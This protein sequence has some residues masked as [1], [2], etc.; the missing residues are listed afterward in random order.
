IPTKGAQ[1]FSKEAL[2]QSK[3][4]VAAQ[5]YKARTLFDPYTTKEAA[6]EFF[7][8]APKKYQKMIG[9]STFGVDL[10]RPEHFGINPKNPAVRRVE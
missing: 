10:S 6:E 2:R 4:M 9:E 3:Q 8:Q 5:V 7:K 1:G